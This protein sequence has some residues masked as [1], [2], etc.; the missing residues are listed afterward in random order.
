MTKPDLYFYENTAK[1]NLFVSHLLRLGVYKIVFSS[2]AAVYG[3]P[4]SVPIPEESLTSPINPYGL[5]K[6]MIEAS[7]HWLE[8]AYGLK[9]VALR[10][11]NAAGASL[12]GSIGE[13]H[14]QETHLIPLVLKTALGQRD[15]IQVFGTD[16]HTPDGTCIRDYIHVLDLAEAHVLALIKTSTPVTNSPSSNNTETVEKSS[17]SLVEQT[18]Q[19]TFGQKTE[20]AEQKSNPPQT[21][22]EKPTPT[23]SPKTQPV[24]AIDVSFVAPQP[25]AWVANKPLI[26]SWTVQNNTS[27]KVAFNIAL[28]DLADS[29]KTYSTDLDLNSNFPSATLKNGV[30]SFIIPAEYIN[31]QGYTLQDKHQYELMLYSYVIWNGKGTHPLPV[32][33]KIKLSVDNAKANLPAPT[34]KLAVT[35]TFKQADP[36]EGIWHTLNIYVTAGGKPLPDA[37]ESI[38]V[39]SKS[40][41]S[42]HH[43][44]ITMIDGTTSLAVGIIDNNPID[45]TI[46]VNAIGQ[47]ATTTA[48]FTSK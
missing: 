42:T 9:W 38:D 35:A 31:T 3:L 29:R 39:H 1:T 23:S 20:Q 33:K 40:Q 11:F 30:Y 45:I 4:E 32:T 27:Y 34:G 25:Y 10:Y 15:A 13:A 2:T 46:K 18:N 36:N 7:F 41:G 48:T 28:V 44:L 37:K 16:Y 47:I 12:D 24:P 6:L 14:S 19:N 43:E 5:S 22:Q 8:R 17:T 26:V 21:N